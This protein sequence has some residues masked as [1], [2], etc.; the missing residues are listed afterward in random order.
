MLLRQWQ[1][2]KS[3]AFNGFK[4]HLTS[5]GNAG[6]Y[7]QR[8]RGGFPDS[9]RLM[10]SIP[11][12]TIALLMRQSIVR[13]FLTSSIQCS[14]DVVHFP[15]FA[16]W[17]QRVTRAQNQRLN[18]HRAGYTLIGACGR[19]LGAR[20]LLRAEWLWGWIFNSWQNW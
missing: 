11:D 20:W 7:G 1:L 9:F 16:A 5:V 12:E 2:F 13:Y 4:D 3:E 8:L 6:K 19:G 18:S 17:E 14:N 15:V 10:T